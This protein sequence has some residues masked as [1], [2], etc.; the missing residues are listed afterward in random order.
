M[1]FEAKISNGGD[2]RIYKDKVSISKGLDKTIIP[3]NQISGVSY[4]PWGE[5]PYVFIDTTSGVKTMFAVDPKD[6]EK[7]KKAIEKAQKS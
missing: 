4:L 5:D 6:K 7:I 3:I 2:L 1:L